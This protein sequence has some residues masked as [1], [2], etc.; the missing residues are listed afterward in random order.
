MN[1]DTI[2]TVQ[3]ALRSGELK[4]NPT[5]CADYLSRLSGEYS[6]WAGQLED[7]E[8][9]KPTTW[10]SLREK[11]KSDKSTDRDY[12]RTEDGI[13]QIGIEIKLKRIATLMSG[14]RTLIRVAEGQAKNNY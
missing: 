4:S 11:N 1:D 5:L 8:V 10:L 9:R 7:I 3:E 14:L 12:E 13:N 6:F 2:L